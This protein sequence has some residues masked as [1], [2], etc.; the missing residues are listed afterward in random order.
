MK[1][2]VYETMNLNIPNNENIWA[3]S[4]QNQQNDSAPSDDSDKPGH[5]PSLIRVCALIG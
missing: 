4:W 5:P 2:N 3:A 1:I